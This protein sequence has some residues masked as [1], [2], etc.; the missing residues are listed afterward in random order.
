M[1]SPD[2]ILRRNNVTVT[3]SARE[4]WCS[5]MGSAATR[6]CRGRWRARSNAIFA[7]CCSTMS[8]TVGRA[9]DAYSPERYADLDGY[10]RDVVESAALELSNA[11]FVGHSVSS[12]IR[13]LASRR[14]PGLFSDL[15]PSPRYIDDGDY[16]G[17]FSR[18]QI[19][20][21]LAFLEVNHLGWSA[22]MAPAIVGNPDRPELGA[23]REQLLQHRSRNRAAVRAGHVPVGQSRRLASRRGAQPGAP[24]VADIIAPVAVGEYVHARLPDEQYRCA[25]RGRCRLSAPDEVA[26]AIREFV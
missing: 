10:A 5:R 3:G 24:V 16:H 26:S 13:A 2:T 1:T 23:R 14:A 25:R 22:A 17:G 7:W 15:G 21:L 4:R 20:E 9:F 18:T 19:D 11:V 8:G 12:M 6:R